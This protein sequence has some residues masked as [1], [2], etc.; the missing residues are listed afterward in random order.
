MFVFCIP[1]R[2][3]PVFRILIPSRSRVLFAQIISQFSFHQRLKIFGN[4]PFYNNLVHSPRPSISTFLNWKSS[5]IYRLNSWI[6]YGHN[7]LGT[8]VKKCLRIWFWKFTRIFYKSAIF[9][10]NDFQSVMIVE[11]Q[12]QNWNF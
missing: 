7:F 6:R 3:A 12:I 4:D 5:A 1:W 2:S 11:I 10:R 8:K 9:N